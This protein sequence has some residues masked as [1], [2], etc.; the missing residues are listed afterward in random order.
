MVLEREGLDHGT[1]GVGVD[2]SAAHGYS[3]GGFS[4]MNDGSWSGAFNCLTSTFCNPQTS[5]SVESSP[6]RAASAQLSSQ[7]NLE[8]SGGGHCRDGHCKMATVGLVW[9]AL[10]HNS[11]FLRIDDFPQVWIGYS[12]WIIQHQCTVPK[13][14]RTKLKNRDLMVLGT[15]GP[16]Q[17][18]SLSFGKINLICSLSRC[19]LG[20]TPTPF[21]TMQRTS[22]V[23]FRWRC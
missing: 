21:C 22:L 18:N 6:L 2:H 13:T 23:Y 1:E 17:C 3:K 20:F 9:L 14:Y 10:R 15:F 12:S 7:P 11:N 16:K 5:G 8:L 4:E 19:L